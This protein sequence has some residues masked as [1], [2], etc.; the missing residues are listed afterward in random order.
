MLLRLHAAFGDRAVAERDE[1]RAVA[2]EHQA[3]AEVQR[4]TSSDG[5]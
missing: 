1:Q 5:A 4:A 3:A 2:T